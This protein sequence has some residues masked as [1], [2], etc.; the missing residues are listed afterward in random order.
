MFFVKLSL[1]VSYLQ[2]DPT[3]R[4]QNE[5]YNKAKQYVDN[6]NVVHNNPE[7]AVA[8]IQSF[9]TRLTKKIKKFLHTLQVIESK[10]TSNEGQAPGF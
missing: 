3:K 7:G 1:S 8:L 6:T 10:Q 5:C 2:L 9:N 4:N